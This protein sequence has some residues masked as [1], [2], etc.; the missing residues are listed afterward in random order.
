MCM[1]VRSRACERDRV[2]GDKKGNIIVCGKSFNRE[3]KHNLAPGE[4]NTI[5]FSMRCRLKCDLLCIYS[6]PML[7]LFMTCLRNSNA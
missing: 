4:Y 5:Q 3:Q 1:C 2:R 6:F 7:T